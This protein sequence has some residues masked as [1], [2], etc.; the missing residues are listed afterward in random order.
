[1]PFP[2][3]VERNT[4]IYPNTLYYLVVY[5]ALGSNNAY[6][7]D[8][9]YNTTTHEYTY[10]WASTDYGNDGVIN[11]NIF[12]GC[13]RVHVP[14][15]VSTFN[16]QIFTRLNILKLIK[17]LNNHSCHII[18]MIQVPSV[19][20]WYDETPD[21]LRPNNEYER[22]YSRAEST[23]FYD[24]THTNFYIPKNKKMMCYPYRKIV[25]SNN[26]GGV[27]E[28]RWEQFETTT[29]AG[30]KS[31]TF[32]LQG[33]AVPIPEIMLSP[34]SYRGLSVDYENGLILNDFPKASWG[35]D[36]FGNWWSQ[37]KD[38]FI[39]STI[40][41]AIIGTISA[42]LKEPSVPLNPVGLMESVSSSIGTFVSHKNAPDQVGGQISVSSIRTAQN[43]IGYHLYDMAIEKD[44]AEVIDDYFTMF[45][46][47][48]KK[49]KVPNVRLSNVT[50]RPHWNY[51][52]T[53]GCVIHSASGKGLPSDAESK[54]A[55]IYDK[56]I[57]FWT[58]ASEVGNYS[59]DNSPS[60]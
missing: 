47:A 1:M 43:R 12:L 54:I 19:I 16:E 44:S 31:A 3:N 33:V 29:S 50:L 5:Y 25:V 46:Y 14:L 45:G 18:D 2:V 20:Y 48:I 36:S 53:K 30:L 38:S 21:A 15:R 7:Y 55:S 28:Y 11:H 37:N 9:T 17:E 42:G 10:E 32:K 49:V 13:N 60:A 51:I 35:V 34:T 56:G 8:M 27:N 52:K 58:T 26:A 57:T 39:L 23:R 6:I 41:S 22:S 40:S 59:L 24:S 4:D